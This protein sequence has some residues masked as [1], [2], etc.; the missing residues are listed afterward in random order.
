MVRRL[1]GGF[2]IGILFGG[3]VALSVIVFGGDVL[4]FWV[5]I[6]FFVA[7]VVVSCWLLQ[8]SV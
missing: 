1:I 2:M 4:L 8:G 7:W 6:L 5:G 3:L